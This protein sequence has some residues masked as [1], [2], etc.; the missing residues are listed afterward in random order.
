M[1]SLAEI[2][3]QFGTTITA[4]L[5]VIALLKSTS[6]EIQQLVTG[7]WR[8]KGWAIISKVYRNVNT[9]YRERRAKGVM[10]RKLEDSAL[11]IEIRMYDGCLR[12]D[13]GKSVRAQLE[14][15]TPAKPSWL[16][17]YYVATALEALS[18]EGSIVKAERYSVNGW[19]PRPES[20]YFVTTS[21]YGSACEK[22]TKIE[23]N[24]KCLAFQLFRRCPR[25]FRFE[26][27]YSAE[28][29]SPSETRHKT[30]YPLKDKAPPCD[31]CWEKENRERDIRTLV[32]NI[33][34]YDL[35]DVATP[36]ITGENG[37]FQGAVADT[38]IE[39]QCPAEVSLIKSVVKK[40]IDIRQ[41]QIA[42]CN[43]RSQNEWQQVQKE[44]LAS[45]LK[46]YIKSQTVM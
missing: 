30:T 9:R 6:K 4:I 29:V 46:E 45:T 22:A 33:T 31:L 26:S 16:N 19:P 37:E 14:S 41:E 43:S 17:D 11:R 1:D 8:W 7:F 13:P 10:C 38:C 15:V 21:T 39:S 12:E 24:D 25:E 23:T 3:E 36:D 32:D 2:W 20:Y 28:T 27:Q 40:A 34:K 42:R 18:I 44:E 5:A 35:A